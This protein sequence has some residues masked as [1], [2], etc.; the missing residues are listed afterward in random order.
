MGSI[1]LLLKMAPGEKGE[2]EVQQTIKLMKYK[3][4]RVEEYNKRSWPAQ[5]L[6][7]SLSSIQ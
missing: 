1:D 5:S 6:S 4:W 3:C 2:E 7:L